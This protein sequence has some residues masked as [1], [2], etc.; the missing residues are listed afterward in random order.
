MK[1]V[2]YLTVQKVA[3]LFGEERAR[4]DGKDV[5]TARPVAIGTV[6]SYVRDSRAPKVGGRPPGR[7]TNNPMPLPSRV[8]GSDDTGPGPQAV[9]F[10]GEGESLAD[11]ERRI[12]AWWHSRTG[13][14]VGGG[15]RPRVR[16]QPST[17]ACGCGQDIEPGAMCDRR[18]AG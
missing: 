17:C 2:L 7:Y 1:G 18:V 11:L 8:D 3:Q 15:R 12:R 16:E 4:A 5:A 9:W 10:P 6:Y 13:R 14:G